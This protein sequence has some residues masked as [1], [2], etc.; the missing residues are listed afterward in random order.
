MALSNL[1]V[2]ER[3]MVVGWMIVEEDEGIDPSESANP[4]EVVSSSS[5]LLEDD[6]EWDDVMGD[7]D[8]AGEEKTEGCEGETNLEGAHPTPFLLLVSSFY[9]FLMTY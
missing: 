5:S 8:E 1:I 4:R 9:F 2:N 6:E 7:E 3:L